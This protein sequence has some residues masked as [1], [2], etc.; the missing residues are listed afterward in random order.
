MGGHPDPLNSHVARFRNTYPEFWF[1][2]QRTWSGISIS[3]IRQDGGE[4]LHTII[5]AD[6]DEMQAELA[7]NRDRR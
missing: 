1:T 7:R 2:T 5:T 6:P 4:G 3:A